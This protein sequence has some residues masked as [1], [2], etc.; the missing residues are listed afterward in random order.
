MNGKSPAFV[1]RRRDLTR[2]IDD[3][4]VSGGIL[5]A[6]LHVSCFIP[7]FFIRRVLVFF[8]KTRNCMFFISSSSSV[9]FFI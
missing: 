2:E 3:A 6:F 8:V 4:I 9:V 5:F 1:W 7:I